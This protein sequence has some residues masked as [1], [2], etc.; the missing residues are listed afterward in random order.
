MK[1]CKKRFG[2]VIIQKQGN[3]GKNDFDKSKSFSIEQTESNYSLEQYQEILKFATDLTEKINF[4][5]L[6]KKLKQIQNEQKT[7]SPK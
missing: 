6:I 5:D 3:G 2:Q 4:K 1:V 7:N